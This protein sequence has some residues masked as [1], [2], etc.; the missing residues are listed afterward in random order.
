MVADLQLAAIRVFVH[1]SRRLDHLSLSPGLAALFRDETIRDLSE[2]HG[3]ACSWET[4]S[5]IHHLLVRENAGFVVVGTFD[6]ASESEQPPSIKPQELLDRPLKSFSL[7][8]RLQGCFQH[9]G[10]VTVRNLVETSEPKLLGILN[11]GRKCRDEVRDFLAE[12]SLQTQM[13]FTLGMTADSLSM[14]PDSGELR[15]VYL[16]PLRSVGSLALSR[17]TTHIFSRLGLR[18]IAELMEVSTKELET[19]FNG[20]QLEDINNALH[21]LNLCFGLHVPE[22]QR[23]DLA[24]LASVFREE[25]QPYEDVKERPLDLGLISLLDGIA[26]LRTRQITLRVLGWDGRGGGTLEQVGQEFNLTRERIRQI[27]AK[28][29]LRNGQKR[30]QVRRLVREALRLAGSMVPCRAESLEEAILEAGVT[31][32]TF[33]LEGLVKAADLLSLSPGFSI[34]RYDEERVVVAIDDQEMVSVVLEE[35]RRRISHFG[36]T[37]VGYVRD[38]LGAKG[39]LL[40]TE[41]VRQLVVLLPGFVWLD[42]EKQWFWSESVPRNSLLTRLRKVLAVAREI[43]VASARVSILRDDRMRQIELPEEVLR[44]LCRNLPEVC[45]VRGE[46]ICADR[47]L[48]EKTE[49]SEVEQVFVGVFRKHGGVL[50]RACLRQECCRMSRVNPH[51][52]DRYLANSPILCTHDNS[53]YGL[54]GIPSA[55]ILPIHSSTSQTP[56]SNT[57]EPEVWSPPIEAGLRGDC[58]LIA[59]LAI[60]DPTFVWSCACRILSRATRLGRLNSGNR[61]SIAELGW[62]ETDLSTLKNW[63]LEGLADLDGLG[64]RTIEQGE[65]RLTGLQSLALVFLAFCA[66]VARDSA[67]EGEL[68]PYVHRELGQVN[69]SELFIARGIPKPRLRDLTEEVCRK[70]EIRH[71]FGHEGALSWL[72]TVYLQFGITRHGLERLPLWL[73]GLSRPTVTISDLL[74]DRDLQSADFR[75]A[76]LVLQELRRGLRDEASVLAE[77]ACNPWVTFGTSEPLTRT[78]RACQREN[79]DIGDE[80][81]PVT[82]VAAIFEKKR[83]LW[84]V[85]DPLF[86]VVVAAMWPEGFTETEYAIQFGEM[87]RGVAR[88]NEVG[89]FSIDRPIFVPTTKKNIAVSILAQDSPTPEGQFELTL[90]DEADEILL[91]DLASGDQIDIWDDHLNLN[92][93]CLILCKSDLR[94]RPEAIR[95]RRI[96]SGDWTIHCFPAGLP[97]DL[98]VQLDDEILWTAPTKQSRAVRKV[99]EIQV[100]CSGGP[101]GHSSPIRIVAEPTLHIR[102]LHVGRQLLRPCTS[103]SSS[104]FTLELLPDV[105]YSRVKAS[106]IVEEN[107]RLRRLPA[108]FLLQSPV[109]GV[110]IE[111]SGHWH[112]VNGDEVLDRADLRGRRLLV[113]PPIRWHGDQVN[114]EDWA[115]LEGSSFCARLR[116]SSITGLDGI[117]A[118]LGQPL[119]LNIGPY[120]NNKPGIPIA[121]A[122]TDSGIVREA[123]SSATD[124]SIRLRYGIEL[125]SDHQLLVWLLSQPSPT[126]VGRSSWFEQGRA[127]VLQNPPKDTIAYAIAYNGTWLGSV[128]LSPDH[129][130]F[131]EL[132]KTVEDWSSLARWLQWWR[133]PLLYGPIRKALSRRIQQEPIATFSTWFSE[134]GSV[135][136]KPMRLS[137]PSWQI[138]MREL[139]WAWSPSPTD[140]AEMLSRIGLLSGNPMKDI[141]EG[142]TGLRELVAINPV[143][144]SAIVVRGLS[145]LY[146]S[147]SQAECRSLCMIACNE[148]ADLPRQAA[149]LERAQHSLISEAAHQMRVDRSFIEKGLLREAVALYHGRYSSA[150]NLRVALAVQPF[151]QWLA[152]QLI[153]QH[154]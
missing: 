28:V 122:V 51:T 70:L 154:G 47:L 76:W 38:A 39:R 149:N 58:D 90:C 80:E 134:D 52:F 42:S 115:L 57:T 82:T 143:L 142:W 50:E 86:E 147:A 26:D 6:S 10:I 40:T 63:G 18:F 133:V 37:S 153:Q 125:T 69:A 14:I 59:D 110:A 77:L 13:N 83:L 119:T 24:D 135:G 3:Q 131:V 2:A 138:I 109:I 23:N 81:L 88:R 89:H 100:I 60:D 148:I 68:W 101:I 98:R 32:Q 1:P 53:L 62:S 55:L 112:P 7:S 4:A 130:G 105:D 132:I 19:H 35:A 79:V 87:Y 150:P 107:S 117:T 48:Q 16:H 114:P 45:T 126:I 61:W 139:F 17:S 71:A 118:G 85:D 106:V 141:L 44:E 21:D 152:I 96:F 93:S 56:S 66:T 31:A 46:F 75:K 43:S 116:R 36:L 123:H 111:D 67:T 84:Q 74:D 49:L 12:L 137:H 124:C 30:E 27:V 9:A 5:F 29:P 151:R 20:D 8:V 95:V 25:L 140:S 94:V 22:W 113:R 78:I 145:V 15:V 41:Q 128:S 91:F 103:S 97:A 127:I 146:P 144:S 104:H 64:S 99:P 92:R 54:V 34:V 102:A 33:R 73:P 65:L 11:F 72:R 108:Y 129:S 136:H 120:N 121:R